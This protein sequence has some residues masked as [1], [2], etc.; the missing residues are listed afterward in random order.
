MST[1][2]QILKDYARSQIG[3]IGRY[4]KDKDGVIHCVWDTMET[5]RT[6]RVKYIIESEFE[7]VQVVDT[8]DSFELLPEDAEFEPTATIED[9]AR[10]FILKALRACGQKTGWVT[11]DSDGKM[12]IHAT[13]L[14][15]VINGNVYWS[16]DP[17]HF[18]SQMFTCVP[19]SCFDQ[20]HF[21]PDLNHRYRVFQ[22]K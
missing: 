17:I 20:I 4:F 15:M 11:Q 14:P 2:P 10:D 1:E 16:S 5:F 21:R 9:E 22:V 8:L 3:S 12:F 18:G 6:K 7:Q 13:P 19:V